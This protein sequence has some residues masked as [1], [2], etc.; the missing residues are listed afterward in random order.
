MPLRGV[1]YPDFV[2]SRRLIGIDYG[3]RRI[4]VAA[5]DGALAVPVS[6][7]EHRSRG[8]DLERVA[9]IVREREASV[10]VVGLP[11]LSSGDEGEQARRCRRFGEALA[12]A[13]G[14]PVEYQDETLSSVEAEAAMAGAGRVHAAKPVDD[15]AA[16]GILQAYIDER[17]SCA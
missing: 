2:T 3:E 10:I 1:R 12:R 6:I 7:V 11:V 9:E 14:L 15:H 13:T 4:G 17:E 16:A 5:S 8:D